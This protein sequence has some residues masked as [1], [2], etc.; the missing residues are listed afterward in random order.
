MQQDRR[1]PNRPLPS[2]YYLSYLKAASSEKNQQG[3]ANRTADGCHADRKLRLA[4]PKLV[5]MNDKKLPSSLSR[6]KPSA[7]PDIGVL[8]TFHLFAGQ[9]FGLLAILDLPLR[10]CNYRHPRSTPPCGLRT[11]PNAR[12]RLHYLS[13]HSQYLLPPHVHAPSN[14]ERASILAA[15]HRAVADQFFVCCC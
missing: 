3:R 10:R 8:L 4:H 2:F 12:L 15:V 5:E 9:C 13:K 7:C 6:V 11:P 1:G 14:P